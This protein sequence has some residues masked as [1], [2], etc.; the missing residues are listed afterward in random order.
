MGGGLI[1]HNGGKVANIIDLGALTLPF[2]NN[3]YLQSVRVVGMK[4][5]IKEGTVLLEGEKIKLKREPENEY[6]KYAIGLFTEKDEKIG[7]IQRRTNKIFARLM[8]GGKILSAEIR[9][10]EFYFQEIEDV[11]IRIF[12]NDM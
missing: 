3:I 11:W 10:V 1:K 6:D 7:Y 2:A 9:I 8:D 4:Y 5:Y 12:L